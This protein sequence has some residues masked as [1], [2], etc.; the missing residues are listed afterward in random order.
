MRAF[1]YA[2][3][4]TKEDAVKLLEGSSGQNSVLAGGTDL[5]SLMKDDVEA[6]RR[7]VN[8]KSVKELYGISYEASNGLRIGALATFDDLLADATVREQYPAL[9]QAVERI[10]GPQIRT[11]STVGGN[12]CQRPRCWY[13]RNGFGLL[14]RLNGKSMVL[15]GD[16]RH[17]AI[18]GNSGPAYFVNPSSLAS[19]LIALGAKL[20][21]YGPQG[22]RQVELENF[23]LIPKEENEKEFGLAANE[24]ITDVLVPPAANRLSAAYA[25]HQR[26]SLDWALV[27]AAVSLEIKTQQVESARVVLAQVAPIPWVAAE[28]EKW[29]VGKTITA[30][31]AEQAGEAAVRGAR[32]LSGN[33]YKIKLARVAVKRALLRATGME[34]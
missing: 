18:L 25:I 11:M 8:I 16:N 24:I 13:Y 10:G 22:D 14:A 33:A 15:E 34:V 27:T 26:E 28:A 29:L 1:E 3:P 30:D 32:S 7:I 31:V 9:V 23:Y 2:S 20:K 19:A 17:H 5:L 4:L 6:P 21:I 12:L